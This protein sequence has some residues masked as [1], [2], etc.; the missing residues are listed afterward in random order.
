V[1]QL[2]SA[3]ARLRGNFGVGLVAEVLTGAKN[4]R[5]QRWGFEQLS[6]HGILRAHSSKRVIAMLHRIM[7]AGLARQRDPDGIKF[8]PVIE[9]TSAGVAVMKGEVPPPATLID[10]VPRSGSREST[11]ATRIRRDAS[12]IGSTAADDDDGFE[13]DP[14]T[15]QRFE[16]LR[17][18][19][20][21]LARERQLPP[22]C[23]CHDRTLKL[24]AR[25]APGSVEDLEK[26]KGMGPH[27]VRMY[28]ERLI[29]ALTAAVD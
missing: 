9:L 22:Y 25:F 10:L 21:E 14:E 5:T 2:L 1:R 8:R 11:S 3:I 28:G 26:I 7:E 19:R 18:V 12:Q 23:I 16:R 29:G 24:I 15:I 4:E 20:L 13:P 27:K 6:V 17:A